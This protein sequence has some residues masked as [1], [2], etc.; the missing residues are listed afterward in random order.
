MSKDMS[1]RSKVENKGKM[2]KET[3]KDCAAK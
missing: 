1:K 2:E 3:P